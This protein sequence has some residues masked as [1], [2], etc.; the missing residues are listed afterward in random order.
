M[1][2]LFKHALAQ[3]ATYESIMEKT[4]KELHLKI[5]A[6]IE[7]VFAG[8]IHEF[9]GMLAHHYSKAGQTG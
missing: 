6:S 7:K 5:A 2:F 8:R 1:E 3:Q 4:K 9:Y